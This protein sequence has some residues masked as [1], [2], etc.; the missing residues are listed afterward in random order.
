MIINHRID[1]RLL[2]NQLGSCL[3]QCDLACTVW[4]HWATALHHTTIGNGTRC[5]LTQ[6]LLASTVW[7]DWTAGALTR[8][9]CKSLLTCTVRIDR[10]TKLCLNAVLN[11]DFLELALRLE[12]NVV[13]VVLNYV[14]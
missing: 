11:I 3:T 12:L 8:R 14:I 4:I 13:H 7:I 2:G 6:A 5:L 1:D 9:R 10:A